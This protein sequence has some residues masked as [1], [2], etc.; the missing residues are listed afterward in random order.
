VSA[1]PGG[2][3]GARPVAGW[4][5]TGRIDFARLDTPNRVV[6]AAS[7]L[8]FLSLQLPWY[9]ISAAGV[10]GSASAMI[11]G[12]WRWLIWLIS[13][14]T[15][16][17]VFLGSVTSW[18]DPKLLDAPTRARML[19]IATGLDLVLVLLA[20]FVSKPV[21]PAVVATSPHVDT[22]LGAY[23]GVVLALVALGAAVLVVRTVGPGDTRPAHEEEDS[24][25]FWNVSGQPRAV[26]VREDAPAGG[27]AGSGFGPVPGERDQ[28][29][30][31]SGPAPRPDEP[32]SGPPTGWMPPQPP[33]PPPL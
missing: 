21:P 18:R 19:V 3:T 30:P 14:A 7:L 29:R 17:Y 20:A 22:S 8:L 16:V 15:L 33:P 27:G 25:S 4:Q 2:T 9:T 28:L 12:G 31:R 10:S 13:L 11:A 26:S 6:G 32:G 1:T 23:L 5:P 24:G